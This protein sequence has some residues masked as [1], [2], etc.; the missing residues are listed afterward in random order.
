MLEACGYSRVIYY[1]E[2]HAAT[3]NRNVKGHQ[4]RARQLD[5]KTSNQ[6]I[7]FMEYKIYAGSMWVFK[8]NLLSR[9]PCSH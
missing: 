8:G 3:E 4:E 7:N 1:Q 2:T 6:K 9:D 5:R